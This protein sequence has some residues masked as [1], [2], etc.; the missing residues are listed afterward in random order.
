MCDDS[1]CA[2]QIHSF[3]PQIIYSNDTIKI[4][5]SLFVLVGHN[6]PDQFW[7]FKVVRTNSGCGWVACDDKSDCTIKDECQG[8]SFFW[9]SNTSCW[10]SA[11]MV[12]HDA[13]LAMIKQSMHC[14]KAYDT[15][16]QRFRARVAAP[17]SRVTSFWSFGR[18]QHSWLCN[19]S[20]W[21]MMRQTTNQNNE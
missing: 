18:D 7:L 14:D 3:T 11:F 5:H 9:K 16:K 10:G 20:L 8:M 17:S 19:N 15:T 1:F 4:Y 12:F 13:N 6:Q 2:W 21:Q